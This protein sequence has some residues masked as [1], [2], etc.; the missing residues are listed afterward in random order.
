MDTSLWTQYFLAAL[1]ISLFAALLFW[2]WRLWRSPL[3]NRTLLGYLRQQSATFWLT[4]AEGNQLWHNHETQAPPLSTKIPQQL[5]FSDDGLHPG[6]PDIVA[7]LQIQPQWQGLVWVGDSSR[8]ALH[9]QVNTLT[10]YQKTYLLWRWRPAQAQLDHMHSEVQSCLDP[11]TGL[12][13]SALWR[14]WLQLQLTRHQLRYQSFAVVLLELTDLPVILHNFGP[15]A[16]DGLLQQLIKN[17][18]M[19]IPTSAFFARSGPQTLAILLSLDGHDDQPQQ[20]ALQLTREILSFCQGPFV[21]PAAE[22]RLDCHAGIAV[23]PDA[24]HNIDELQARAAQ[25]LQIASA[26]PDKLY[27]WQMQGQSPVPGLQLQMELQQALTQYQLEIWSQPVIELSAGVIR[28]IRLEL[29][30]RSPTRGLVSYAELRPLAEQTGQL[31]ALERWAFC[32]IC[33]LMELWQ[34]LGTL[35]QV[36]IELSAANFRHSGLLTFLQSQLQDYQLSPNQLMLCLREDGWLQDPNGFSAQAEA[37]KAAG[38]SLMIVGVGHGVGPL[39]FLQQPYWQ[40]AEL[41]AQLIG[42][43][44]DSDTQRNACSSLIRLLIH[45]GLRVHAQG[46]DREMQAYLLHVMGCYSG[47]GLHFSPMRKVSGQELPAGLQHLWQQAS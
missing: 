12:P 29:C 25:A 13:S 19:E 26:A 8:Q 45:Q 35:P 21:L 20:Q 30:W 37:L 9:L 31:L 4:D 5:F 14:Y 40:A 32:Q 41:S 22:L 39:Q 6:F 38:F 1:T 43:L 15:A 10:G 46:V 18:Q 34:R 47:R 16:A 33:Q 7:M 36:Q 3:Q 17:V 27:L 23:F 2:F 42:Q 28:A 44:E 24:G 11:V